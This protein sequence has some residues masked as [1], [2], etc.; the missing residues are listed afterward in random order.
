LIKVL[1]FD[2]DP[3]VFA[4]LLVNSRLREEDLLVLAESDRASAVKLRLLAADAK[5][6][7]RY[8]IR[9]ALAL[10]PSTPRSDAASQLR[11]MTRRDLR[12]IHDHPATSTYL[13]RCIER[14]APSVFAREMERID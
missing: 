10:N 14:L 6:S 5:W 4:A 12:T 2:P 8:A 1:L 13:R 7:F 3:N 11:F 9:R